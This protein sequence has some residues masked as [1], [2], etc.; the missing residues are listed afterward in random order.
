M[1]TLIVLC[2]YLERTAGLDRGEGF[3]FPVEVSTTRLSTDWR[4]RSPGGLFTSYWESSC[5]S[6]NRRRLVMF[7]LT[8]TPILCVCL[9]FSDS[10]AST[11]TYPQTSLDPLSSTEG[12]SCSLVSRL[13]SL[14][15][16]N[17]PLKWNTL[18]SCPTHPGSRRS[19][20]ARTEPP[21]SHKHKR[22]HTRT[23]VRVRPF[24]H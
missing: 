4:G 23:H 1:I 24:D 13:W 8:P 9:V 11:F 19:R 22:T 6:G 21:Y 7:H 15:G 10:S 12:S 2:K 16:E 14:S 20:Y 3:V 18:V 5:L 17:L